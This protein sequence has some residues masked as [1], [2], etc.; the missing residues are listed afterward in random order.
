MPGWGAHKVNYSVIKHEAG[1][2]AP[3]KRFGVAVFL[4]ANRT[5]T[6]VFTFFD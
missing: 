2:F 5:A 3:L 1:R 4:H 6:G